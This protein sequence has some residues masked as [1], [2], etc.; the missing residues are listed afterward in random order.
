MSGFLPFPALDQAFFGTRAAAFP[1]DRLGS[2]PADGERPIR[3]TPEEPAASRTD[4]S[5]P[6]T[7]ETFSPTPERTEDSR[8]P[9]RETR[10]SEARPEAALN[11]SNRERAEVASP[12]APS[13]G[14]S[15]SRTTETTNGSLS[16][17]ADGD[18]EQGDDVSAPGEKRAATPNV[19]GE[20]PSVPL[21]PLP[22]EPQALISALLSGDP[23]LG[24]ANEPTPAPAVTVGTV[25]QLATAE[26]GKEVMTSASTAPLAATPTVAVSDTSGGTAAVSPEAL[27]ARASTTPLPIV[28]PPSFSAL[29][30]SPPSLPTPPPTIF[31]PAGANLREPALP[32]AAIHGS[33]ATVRQGGQ[34]IAVSL[35]TTQGRGPVPAGELA[36]AT[37]FAVTA[38]RDGALPPSLVPTQADDIVAT[39]R[40]SIP[41]NGIE[42]E[43][44]L[45]GHQ[46]LLHGA[47]T[48]AD[49]RPAGPIAVSAQAFAR[50]LPH[51]PVAEQVSIQ[52]A[53]GA[54]EGL[55]R[56]NIQLRPA[57]LGRVEVRLDVGQDGRIS[58]VISADRS[59]TLDLLQRDARTLERALQDAGL[60]ADT[61]S[62]SFQLHGHDRDSSLAQ[63]GGQGALDGHEPILAA[64]DA[65]EM[66]AGIY[67]PIIEPGRVD[68]RV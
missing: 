25:P 15:A 2:R 22:S 44:L 67:R 8:T 35:A 9:Q 32:G 3:F 17:S 61:G 18:A 28:A 54:E 59:D 37:A 5:R 68:L 58:A 51:L 57:S 33:N 6:S 11:G 39:T 4:P 48:M 36:H 27:A 16:A 21:T 66:P 40:G 38:L 19:A 29:T 50:H 14:A 62:L 10:G 42:S 65:P 45:L 53:H 55:D 52:I 23:I 1:A 49:L 46:S 43:A 24:A 30:S 20:F 13:E 34:P 60:R 47:G 64:T 26:N 31:D 12:T 41:V 63:D 7:Q 56:I